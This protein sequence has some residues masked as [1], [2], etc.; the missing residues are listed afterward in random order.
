MTENELIEK[1]KKH[2]ARVGTQAQAAEDFDVSTQFLTDVL[3]GRRS[4][5]RIADYFG[6]TRSVK[7]EKVK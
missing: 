5:G 2:I 7:Y 3:H 1:I 6:L 4:P